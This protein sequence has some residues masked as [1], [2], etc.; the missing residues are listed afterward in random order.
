MDRDAQPTVVLHHH[1][2]DG[3]QRQ[4]TKIEAGKSLPTSGAPLEGTLSL[5][6]AVGIFCDAG[7]ILGQRLA[8]GLF[9][10]DRLLFEFGQIKE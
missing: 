10:F 1:I 5:E 7:T 2:P 9:R 6:D 8:R 3:S 4:S